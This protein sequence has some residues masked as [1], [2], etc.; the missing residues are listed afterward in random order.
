M[1]KKLYLAMF[2]LC[3]IVSESIA[4]S[5]ADL[6]LQEIEVYGEKSEVASN[7][8]NTITVLTT[9]QVQSLPATSL[10]EILDLLPGIDIRTRGANGAQADISMRGGTNDQVLIM[11]N[12]VNITDPRTG[13]ANLDIPIAKSAISRIE[14][15]QGTAIE[16]FGFNAFAGAINIITTD[17]INDKD[18]PLSHHISLEGGGYGYFAP[19][20]TLRGQHQTLNWIASA[21]YNRSTGFMHNT[22]YDY[23]NLYTA[24]QTNN[25]AGQWKWQ[26]GGQM[27]K[28]GSNGFYTLKYPDQYEQTQ[29]VVASVGWSKKISRW[30][31]ESTINY[32]LHRDKWFLF[33]PDYD[34]YPDNYLPNRHITQSGGWNIKAHYHT[35]LGRTSAGLELRNE[36]ILS[37]VLGEQRRDADN[38]SVYKYMKNRFNVNYFVQQSFVRHNWSAQVGIAGNYNTMFGHHYS[39]AAQVGYSYAYKSTVYANINRTFRMPTFTDLYYQSVTQIANPQLHPEISYNFELGTKYNRIFSNMWQLNLAASLYYRIG[40]NIIDWIKRPED[41][42]WQSANHTRVDAMGG[43]AFIRLHDQKW[44]ILASYSFAN[45]NQSM[46]DNYNGYVSKYALDYLRHKA[47]IEFGHP[48][49]KGFGATWT[50]SWQQRHGDYVDVSGQVKK[51]TPVSLFDGCVYWKNNM[52]KVYVQA[53]NLLNISYYDYGGIAQPGRWLKA[54]IHIQL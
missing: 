42:K 20:Y 33:R 27:K 49:W 22:D 12:G 6:R 7:L 19:A 38:I 15:L 13:H 9:E 1:K 31:L 41:E 4:Q 26:L 36:N 29:T 30:T 23:G 39:Y 47:T 14:I 40:Q 25:K 52:I 46:E 53:S 21:D 2:L 8:R 50:F 45:L 32:R 11:L 48:I 28:F 44:H 35:I 3:F 17:P 51:Y 16:H 10:N 54:G 24:G 43:E 5:A 34:N 37:S 18:K